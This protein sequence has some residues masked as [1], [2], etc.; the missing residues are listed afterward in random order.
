[1]GEQGRI[2]AR[3]RQKVRFGDSARP[4]GLASERVAKWMERT[5]A[6]AF[7]LVLPAGETHNARFDG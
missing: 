1:M 5:A 4:D 3:V 2:A 7:G 6:K